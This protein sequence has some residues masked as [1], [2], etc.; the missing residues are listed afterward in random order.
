MKLK[1]VISLCHQRKAFRLFDKISECGEIVQWMG[2]GCAAYPLNGLPIL[3]EETLCAVF[4]I[5]EKQ[6]KNTSVQRLTMPDAPNVSDTDPDERVL[7]DDDFSITYGGTEVLPLRTRTGIIF[8]Q[9]KYLAPLEDVLDV[10]Q[11]YERVTT[12]GQTYVAAKAGLLIAAVIFP[13]RIVNE[14]FVNRIEEVS[15]ESRRVLND[16]PPVRMMERDT[17]QGLMFA[18]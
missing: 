9:K 3:D 4:D 11:L 2:D 6:L 1:K 18:E 16:P 14:K 12:D 10:V 8:I 7:K 13:Y 17:D 5:S 15:R